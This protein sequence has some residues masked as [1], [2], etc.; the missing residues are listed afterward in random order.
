MENTAEIPAVNGMM[1]FGTII[2]CILC[3]FSFNTEYGPIFGIILGSF[4]VVS[5]IGLLISYANPYQ[6]SGPIILAIGSFGFVPIGL[7]AIFGI[8]K[9]MDAINKYELEK[10]RAAERNQVD[11]E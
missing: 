10:R 2:N 6:K 9:H 11:S 8:R 4:A 1:V 3:L 7:V 5:I